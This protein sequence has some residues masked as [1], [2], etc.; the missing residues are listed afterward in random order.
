MHSSGARKEIVKKGFTKNE[1]RKLIGSAAVGWSEEQGAEQAKAG[2]SA[3]LSSSR[4]EFLSVKVNSV[5]IGTAVDSVALAQELKQGRVRPGWLKKSI[6]IT[7]GNNLFIPFRL[8]HCPCFGQN[9]P[10]EV[11][12]GLCCLSFGNLS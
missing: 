12:K 5:W 1:N 8:A 2:L 9:H 10:G 3:P 4:Q 6:E 7:S 11:S